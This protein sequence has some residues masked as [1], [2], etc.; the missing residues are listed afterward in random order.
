MKERANTNP[1]ISSFVLKRNKNFP[2]SRLP[3]L[4]YRKGMMLPEQNNKAASI[5]Q[6]LFIRN[7]W[8]NSWRNGIYDF[9]HYHSNT[10]EC[11]AICMGSAN[12]ILGGPNGKR[13]KLK[14][15]DVIILPAGVG[16]RCTAKSSDFLCVG[17]YPEGKD[18]DTNTGTADE[19]KKAISRMKAVPIPKHDPLFGDQGF[20]RSYWK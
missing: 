19:Y 2:N 20:L 3:V 12:V 16:H 7:G 1:H 15:G 13:V 17:A 5:A 9:H 4:I 6:K 8:S 11:M 10:H 14:Q 18:Y